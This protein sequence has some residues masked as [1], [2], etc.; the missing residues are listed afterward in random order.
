[1]EIGTAAWG[2][3]NS[4]ELKIQQTS[5]ADSNMGPR[6]R[7]AQK[8]RSVSNLGP[9]RSIG[10]Y[11][12]P[13]CIF[14]SLHTTIKM[15]DRGGLVVMSRPRVQ[16]A[17]GPRPDPTEDQ[18]CLRAPCVGGPSSYVGGHTSSRWC[19]VDVQRGAACLGFVLV[20]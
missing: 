1:M 16:G 4:N 17:P 5:C 14:D 7:V 12:I 8:F 9:T 10:R 2:S 15:G 11:T 6:A 19:D 20:I 18:P 13:K 3:V